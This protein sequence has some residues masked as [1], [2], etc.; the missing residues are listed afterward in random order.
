MPSHTQQFGTLVKP[1]PNR[2]RV[3]L[4]G[5]MNSRTYQKFPTHLQRCTM[6]GALFDIRQPDGNLSDH[7]EV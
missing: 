1:H 3:R 5:P 4:G 7:F 6:D 2:K